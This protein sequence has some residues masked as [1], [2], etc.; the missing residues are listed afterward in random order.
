MFAGL[1]PGREI[2]EVAVLEDSSAQCPQ[3]HPCCLWLVCCLLR[4]VVVAAAAAVAAVAAVAAAVAAVV[5]DVV[6]FVFACLCVFVFVCVLPWQLKSRFIH[7]SSNILAGH[8][9]SFFSG[10]R[11]EQFYLNVP[12]VNTHREKPSVSFTIYLM[13][14]TGVISYCIITQTLLIIS[15]VS[16]ISCF[17][18]IDLTCTCFFQNVS[19]NRKPEE[20]LQTVPPHE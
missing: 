17:F 6:V 18:K 8:F 9:F 12:A 3:A 5:D 19:T 15:V 10:C 20:A 2:R 11:V 4:F 14:Q 7:S 13:A 1:L 16:K